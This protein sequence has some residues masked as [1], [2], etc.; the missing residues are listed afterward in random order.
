MRQTEAEVRYRPE[1]N[2]YGGAPKRVRLCC[3]QNDLAVRR[4]V[5]YNRGQYLRPE[6]GGRDVA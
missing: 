6:K 1:G 2:T 3:L 5:D 4:R